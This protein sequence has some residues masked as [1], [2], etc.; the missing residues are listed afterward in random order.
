MN[1]DL[2]KMA[3]LLSKGPDDIFYYFDDSVLYTS[4]GRYY[5]KMREGN[6]PDDKDSILKKDE[7][8]RLITEYMNTNNMC[9]RFSRWGR[10]LLDQPYNKYQR[11]KVALQESLKSDKDAI[12]Y[13]NNMEPMLLNSGYKK[14]FNGKKGECRVYVTGASPYVIALEKIYFSKTGFL[15][16][17]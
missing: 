6:S 16:T 15:H 9:A 14:V 5:L 7:F 10:S 11:P 1:V 8:G 12:R 17:G 3:D 4:K 13:F 2:K